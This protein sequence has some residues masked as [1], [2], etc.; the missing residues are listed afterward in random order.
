MGSRAG[1]PYPD[2]SSAKER[3]GRPAIFRLLSI[4]GCIASVYCGNPRVAEAEHTRWSENQGPYPRRSQVLMAVFVVDASVALAWCFEDEA[5]ER[6]V[7][8]PLTKGSV[9]AQRLSNTEAKITGVRIHK[10]W[11]DSSIA[12]VT[13]NQSKFVFAHLPSLLQDLGECPVEHDF[14]RMIAVKINLH[15]LRPGQHEFRANNNVNAF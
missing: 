1:L 10:P 11:T 6:R 12:S 8:N 3:C 14:S 5:T 4:L 13:M 15:P 2:W 9:V 7:L